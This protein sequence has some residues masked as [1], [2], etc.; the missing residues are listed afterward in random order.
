[1]KMNLHKKPFLII[2]TA[3]FL[4]FIINTSV[5]TYI[6]CNRYKQTVLSKL[7]SVGETIAKEI[8]KDLSRGI[9][10]EDLVKFN[11]KIN[12]PV[13]DK[14]IDYSMVL[15]QDGKILFHSDEK[16]IGK[17]FK[18]KGT[19][20]AIASKGIYAQMWGVYYDVSLPLVDAQ[21][22]KV[23]I[24][25]VGVNSA[26][27]KKELYSFLVRVLI[28]SM[29][30]FLLSMAVIYYTIS[31]FI[32]RPIIEIEKIAARISSGDLTEKITKVGTGEISSLAEAVN[33]MAFSLKDVLLKMKEFA[34]NVST[35]TSAITEYPV[36]VLKILDVQRNAVEENTRYITELNS[37]IASVAMNS[38]NLYESVEK[39]NSALDAMT[40]T[41]YNVTENTN[42]F[43]INSL[44]AAASVEEMMASIKETAKSIE[45]LYVTAEESNTAL[46]EVNSAIKEIQKSAG[47]SVKLAEK[48]SNEAS[49]KGLASVS[50]A[51]K[52]IKDIKEN[53]NAISE[54]IYRL[55]KR[56]NEIGNILIVIDEVAAQ[57]NL[58]SLNA[59][60]LAAQAGEHGK[61]FTVVADEI[62]RLAEKTS[63]STREIAE[64]IT[65][66]Q[67]ETRSS[68]EL[69]ANGI[70]TVDKGVKL[71]GEVN[72]AL[73]SILGSSKVSTEM[74]RSIQRATTEEANVIVK[75]TDFIKQMVNQIEHISRATIE[76][77]K[78]SSI[79]IEASEKIKAGSE[80][81]KSATGDQ[82][83]NIQNIASVS[84]NVSGQTEKIK[85][86]LNDQIQSSETIITSMKRIQ[87]ATDEVIVS[88]TEIDKK[89]SALSN[90]AKNVLSEIQKFN[91]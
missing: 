42:I 84:E 27:I 28:L 37:S 66:V 45:I 74:S 90:D 16:N 34:T 58:L 41:V 38:K 51:I 88:I 47:E 65:S 30:L 20:D 60:I 46:I 5:L 25:R 8:G 21:N 79:I 54:M 59:A 18:D 50:T 19:L 39:E 7:A 2:T 36:N 69:V 73:D 23:G 6:T 63:A 78:G 57:T 11:E 82:F 52:G 13:M 85:I 72:D 49:E 87:K 53:V 76:Q 55:E 33:S 15:N 3:L 40:T 81:I 4:V 17:I 12:T 86:A 9:S 68:V 29:I 43:Y 62:K 32:T 83:R 77:N 91:M 22:K 24:L 35:F 48:V 70:K 89:I 44:E 67:T 71:I 80:Q 26:V 10:I 75:I 61:S 14:A 1:M 56:S 64:L 31:R